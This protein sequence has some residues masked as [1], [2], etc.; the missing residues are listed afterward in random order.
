LLGEDLEQ[1]RKKKMETIAQALSLG[2]DHSADVR[3]LASGGAGEKR[4]RE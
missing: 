3:A 2:P 4:R 1:N